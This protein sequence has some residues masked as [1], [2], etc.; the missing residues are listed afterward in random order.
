MGVQVSLAGE[1]I[2]TVI[3]LGLVIGVI[4]LLGWFVRRRSAKGA[5]PGFLGPAAGG[6][7][8]ILG[9]RPKGVAKQGRSSWNAARLAGLFAGGPLS[10][11]V[12]GKGL[13]APEGLRPQ[14]PVEVLSR[15]VVSRG[16]ELVLVSFGPNK[17]LLLGVGPTGISVLSEGD[18]DAVLSEVHVE[19]I[20]LD[21]VEVSEIGEDADQRDTVVPASRIERLRELTVRRS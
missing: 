8:S 1:L 9:M 12:T 15:R 2:R 4:W 3:A 17:V 11:S 14:G 7:G 13:K 6:S 10:A 20:D 19:E 16:F 5:P 21:G 18:A